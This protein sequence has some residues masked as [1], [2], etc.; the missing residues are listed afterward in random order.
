VVA[1]LR[2]LSWNFPGGTDENHEKYIGISGSEPKFELGTSEYEALDPDVLF[3]PCSLVEIIRCFRGAYY[4]HH[5]GGEN[6]TLELRTV[7]TRLHGATSQNTVIFIHVAVR[8]W[9]LTLT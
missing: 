7:F 9:H 6:A 8:T 2:A 4:F 1:L 3:A 5:Q